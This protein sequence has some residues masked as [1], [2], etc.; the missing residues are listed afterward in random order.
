MIWGLRSISSLSAPSRTS[1]VIAA[2][3]IPKGAY[4]L[5]VARQH[6]HD[7]MHARL[8]IAQRRVDI[9]GSSTKH[10]NAGIAQFQRSRPDKPDGDA[11]CVRGILG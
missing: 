7:L 3:A 8:M 5:G 11:G 4:E 9:G 1:L 2:P 6:P 10:F